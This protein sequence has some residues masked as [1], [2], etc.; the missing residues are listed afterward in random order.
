MK[1]LN[2]SNKEKLEIL[3]KNYLTL[4]DICILCDCGVNTAQNIKRDY[5]Q[6]IVLNNI[7]PNLERVETELFVEFRNINTSK[8]KEFASQGY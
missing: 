5:K 1:V 2:Y 8:I 3:A 4:H 6:Y 7:T